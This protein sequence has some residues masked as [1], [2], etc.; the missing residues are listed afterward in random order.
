MRQITLIS[1]FTILRLFLFAQIDDSNELKRLYESKDYDK[2]LSDYSNIVNDLSAK[3]TYYVG[4]AYYMKQEDDR[5]IDMMNLSIKKDSTD[6]DAYFIK[7]MT[8]NYIGKFREAID[9]FQSAIK[10][11]SNSSD[12]YSGL[13]DS[14]IGINNFA[15]ALIAYQEATKKENPIDRPF[16]MIPQIYSAQKKPT[17]ALK[18]FYEAKENISKEGDSYITVLYNI[19]LLELLNDE[20]DKAKSALEELIDLNPEDYPSYS[21]IIQIHYAKKE[22]DKAIPYKKELYKAY[23]KGV[24]KDNLSEMFCFDQFEW[25]DKLIQV[26]E[27]FE[28][29]ESELYYKHLFY[30]VNKENKIEFRIQTENSPISVKL[31]G[32]KYLVGMDKDGEH[33][34]FSYGFSKKIDYDKL[35]ETVIKILEGEIKPTASSRRN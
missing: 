28:E 19:G 29:K 1:I 15:K 35:K 4:M 8:F 23:D 13:G 30:V 3:S 21:K 20:Y 7:G 2:I 25:K 5:C 26:F 11:N 6:S 24:L 22:Y 31:G 27:R 9:A 12:Y 32:A 34:T 17:E 18:Y 16:T 10:I 14:Y 33:Y